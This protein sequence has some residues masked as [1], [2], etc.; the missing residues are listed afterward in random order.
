MSNTMREFEG[1]CSKYRGL[2]KASSLSVVFGS[3]RR[4]S[5]NLVR[6]RRTRLTRGHMREGT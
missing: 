4:K 3:D 1:V 2:E 5:E 6:R